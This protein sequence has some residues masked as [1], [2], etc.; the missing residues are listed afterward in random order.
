MKTKKQRTETL[1][2]CPD[3]RVKVIRKTSGLRRWPKHNYACILFILRA[4]EGTRVQT[5]P[6]GS[7]EFMANFDELK[8][9]LIGINPEF[10]A[11]FPA[12]MRNKPR[13]RQVWW[14]HRNGTHP[15]TRRA[16]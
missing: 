11:M 13:D 8:A 4:Q 2:T 1:Y 9:F 16:E 5:K 6:D 3:Q 7:V 12:A 14:Q 15:K 10:A